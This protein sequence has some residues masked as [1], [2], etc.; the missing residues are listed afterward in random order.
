MCAFFLLI[1]FVFPL[2]VDTMLKSIKLIPPT[3]EMGEGRDGYVGFLDWGG[4]GGWVL[5]RH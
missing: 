4:V 1:V 2:T 3:Q 5:L